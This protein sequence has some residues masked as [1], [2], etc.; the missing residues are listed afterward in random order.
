MRW[1]TSNAWQWVVPVVAIGALIAVV[2]LWGPK[3]DQT[4]DTDTIWTCSMHPQVRLPKPGPCPICGMDLIPLSQLSAEQLRLEQQAGLEAEKVAYRELA[5]EVRTVGKLDYN[6]T[7]VAY[8]SARVPGRIDRLY[9]GFTG[10]V[11][12]AGDHLLDIYSPKLNVDQTSLIRALEASERPQGNR[13]VEL[14]AL[15]ATRERLRLLG[16][17]PQ[18]IEEIER[19]RKATDHMTIYAP[20]GG[21]VIEKNDK[22]RLGQYIEQGDTLYRIAELDP[23]WLYLDVYEYDLAWVR[24]G[25]AVEVAVE[26]YPGEEFKGMVTFIDPFLDDKTRAVKVR[27]NLKNP[28][29]R[30]K[31]AMYATATVRARLRPDGTPEPT[32]LEGKYVCPMH[33]EVIQDNPGRCPICEMPLERVP[34]TPAVKNAKDKVAAQHKGKVLAVRASAVLDTG[35]RQIAYR[36]RKDAAYEL[37]ELRLGPAASGKDDS[38]RAQRYYPVLAGLSAGDEVVVQGGFLLDSQRQI[39][40][41]PSLLYPEGQ[42]G[43]SLHAGHE[44]PMPPASPPSGGPHKH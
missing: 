38:G 30:L 39:D 12:N 10:I 1:L 37:V 33:P 22:A 13:K 15:E 32:G 6:E 3:R 21:T 23:I 34:G 27:V 14:E 16:I 19:T 31:P 18:Q 25:Q 28:D 20:I 40:R 9:V 7:R 17:M 5:K 2:F 43:A 8:I 41:M 35:R 24:Y 29:R 11:V 42:S 4:A 44:M 26:A 36:K